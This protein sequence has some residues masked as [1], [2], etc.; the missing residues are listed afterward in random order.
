MESGQPR[1]IF[2]APSYAAFGKDKLFDG[3]DPLL[4]RDDGLQPTIRLRQI[5][6]VQGAEIHTDDYLLE[7]APMNQG[8]AEYYSF[9]ILRDYDWLQSRYRLDFRAFLIFEPPFVARKLYKALPLLSR[10]FSRIYLHNIHGDGYSLAGVDRTK[11]RK[12]FWPQPFDDVLFDYWRNS[13]RLTKLV[14]INGNHNP[15]LRLEFGNG[16]LYS[17][18]IAAMADLAK[19]DAVDLY[20]RGWAQWWHP[21]SMWFPYLSNY[22][23]LM[24]IYKG[25][26]ISKY[27]V[28]SR[29]K[30]SLCLENLCMDGYIT[31]KIFDCLYVG[32]IPIYLGAKDVE[33]Y[34]PKDAYIDARKFQSWKE[35]WSGILQLSPGQVSAMKEAGRAF[36][37]SESGRRYYHSLDR[38]FSSDEATGT[39]STQCE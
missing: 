1:K 13:D 39:I 8:I 25:S 38:I 31:E 11:L 15:L 34:I 33:K 36:L 18:R 30:F 21:N 4:N 26:C 9:G 14:V 16:E 28:L 7:S 19:L 6:A 37:Q 12:L 20:G 3:S 2:I 23:A 24:S 35:M 29:Y 17:A 5:L 27:E 10:Y 32:T 22:Q